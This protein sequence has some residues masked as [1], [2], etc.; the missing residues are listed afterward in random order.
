MAETAPNPHLHRILNPH[1]RSIVE[2]PRFGAGCDGV[3]NVWDKENKK[4]LTQIPG[5]ATSIAALAFNHDGTQLAVAASYTFEHKD[6]AHPADEIF[7]RQM[8]EG[9]VQPK[10]RFPPPR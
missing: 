6:V 3:V 1:P 8:Q 10:R 4:R 9:E 5:Y 2:R 7:V